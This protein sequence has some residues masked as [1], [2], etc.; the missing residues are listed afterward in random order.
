MD[1]QNRTTTTLNQFAENCVAFCQKLLAGINRVRDV[2]RTEFRETFQ[3][4]DQLVRL[5]LNEAEALAWQTGYPH[6]LFPTLAQEK[7]QAVAAW[8]DHQRRVRRRV[9]LQS[10]IV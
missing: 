6:L 4:N 7:V 3:A 5:A 9:L 8:N 1:T 10:A 2:I